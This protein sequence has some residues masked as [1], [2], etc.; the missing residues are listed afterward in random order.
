[1]G[2]LVSYN[3]EFFRGKRVLV[4]GDSGFKGSWLCLLLWKAGA[5]VTGYSLPPKTQFDNFVVTDLPSKIHHIDG[6]LADRELLGSVFK[7]VRPEI[8]FH[9]AAQPLVRLSYSEPVAT[10]ATNV[11]GSV[12]VLDSIRDCSSVRSLI[13]VTSDKCYRNKEW[14]WGYRETDE[15]GGH[16]P[17]SASKAAA[18]IVFE[19]Y[20]LSFFA[21]RG[22]IGVATVRAG[23]VIGGGD[24]STDRIIPDCV[25]FLSDGQPIK[26]RNPSATRP[27]Q[28][29]LE[30]INGY[31]MLGAALWTNP[32]QF[33]G[34]WN[35]GPNTGSHRSVKELVEAVVRVWGSGELVIEPTTDAPHEAG[36]LHLNCDKVHNY[37]GWHPVWGFNETVRK[38]IEW[39]QAAD[40]ESVA[41]AQID[42]YLKMGAADDSRC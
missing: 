34:A 30:P 3:P 14:I 42:Q 8:V 17:Y 32:N 1:M 28:H 38:T 4:T 7:Q 5:E 12:N 23:N 24:W 26:I 25:R 16:D 18:E 15:L 2:T 13:Y 36:F 19:S 40:K 10:F 9:L 22:D 31:M 39:Y 21:P 33:S 11:M 6:D 41:L 27:W 35:F 37:L 20:R 29:V